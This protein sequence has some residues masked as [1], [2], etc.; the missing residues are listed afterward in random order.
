LARGLRYNLGLVEPDHAASDVHAERLRAL[1]AL[2]PQFSASAR[3]AFES[4]NFPELGVKLPTIPGIA[5]L[6][7]SSGGFGYQDIRVTLSQAL[8]DAQLRNRYQARKQDEQASILSIKDAR[9]VVVLA[10]GTAY[11]QV[12]ASVARVE[13]AKAQLAS[14]AEFDRLTGNSRKSRPKS[15]R[16]ARR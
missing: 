4:V 7:V 13:T 11:F 9:G 8:F 3:Q 5:P 1:A 6:P 16:C 14:A 12:I 10:V 2:L 15:N